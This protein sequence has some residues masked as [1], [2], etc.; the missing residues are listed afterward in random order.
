MKN[1]LYL[2]VFTVF[3]SNVLAF[4]QQT[5]TL[6]PYVQINGSDTV[7]SFSISQG[8]ELAYMNEQLKLYKQ[9]SSICENQ[10]SIKDSTIQTLNKDKKILNQIIQSD[11]TQIK[12]LEKK[13]ETSQNENVDLKK[14]VKK[15]RRQKIFIFVGAGVVYLTTIYVAIIT[16]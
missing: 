5:D 10:L 16:K 2:L 11:S 14:E 7:I 6:Y 13:F 12:L 15:L 8:R 3:F 9:V 4:S 1:K